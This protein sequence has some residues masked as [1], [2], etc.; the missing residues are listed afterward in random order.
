MAFQMSHSTKENIG[1]NSDLHPDPDVQLRNLW[2]LNL[3]AYVIILG[4]SLVGN[5]LVI[6]VHAFSAQSNNT[7]KAASNYFLVNMAVADLIVI[8]FNMPIEI[9]TVSVG[10]LWLV[11]GTLGVALCKCSIATW[12][13]AVNASTST[14]AAIA[15]DRFLLVFYPHKKIITKHAACVIIA[16]IWVA[17]F[18]FTLPLFAFSSLQTGKKAELICDAKFDGI[19]EYCIVN[20][21]IFIVTPLIAMTV[22]YSALSVKLWLKKTVNQTSQSFQ[23]DLRMNRKITAMLITIV[24][25]FALCW[26]PF[27]VGTIYCLTAYSKPTCLGHQFSFIAR[28]LGFSNSACNPC[29]YFSFSEGFRQ[30]AKEMWKRFRCFCRTRTQVEAS[31]ANHN[32]ESA[33]AEMGDTAAI[34]GLNRG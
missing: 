7:L 13:T 11:S 15:L 21:S 14:L 2:Q 27:W 28:F 26:L 19:E 22:L 34:S 16:L 12:F 18:L 32:A 3:T 9:K 17:A 20:F 6:A 29:I 23:R 8:V 4:I 31:P 1:N 25:T 24:L 33:L 10:P 5:S 30:G